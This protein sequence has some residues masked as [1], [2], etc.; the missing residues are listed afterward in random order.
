MIPPT[1]IETP[2]VLRSTGLEEGS[3]SRTLSNAFVFRRP[4]AKPPRFGKQAISTISIGNF[5]ELLMYIW[6]QYWRLSNGAINR[7]YTHAPVGVL[8]NWPGLPSNHLNR[9]KE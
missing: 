2:T 1:L 6:A 7:R 5:T 9:G 4:A 3:S 8:Y